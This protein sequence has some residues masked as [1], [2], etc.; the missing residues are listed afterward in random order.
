MGYDQRNYLDDALKQLIDTMFKIDKQFNSRSS[1]NERAIEATE[2]I[3]NYNKIYYDQNH[4]TPSQYQI[5]NYV[6]VR[7]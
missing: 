5:G 6:L 4:K 7:D 2:K 1:K 3:K